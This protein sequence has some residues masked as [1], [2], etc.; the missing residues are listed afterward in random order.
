MVHKELG[1]VLKCHRMKLDHFDLNEELS[2][3]RGSKYEIDKFLSKPN[4]EFE[5]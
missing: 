4:I 2:L 1:G 5:I 3:I